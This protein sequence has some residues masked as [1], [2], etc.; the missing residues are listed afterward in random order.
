[1]TLRLTKAEL[2]RLLGHTDAEMPPGGSER[3]QERRGARADTSTSGHPRRRGANP[4]SEIQA[5]IADALRLH[6][7]YVERRN[8][9]AVRTQAGGLVRLAPVGTPDLFALAPPRHAGAH[10]TPV[11]VEVKRPGQAP[12]PA[13][14]ERHAELRGYGAVVIV[15]H[16]VDEALELLEVYL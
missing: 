14:A 9:G 16:S 4:E 5:A 12:T 10:A 2:A 6:G 1:M 8:S 3:P 7:C 15:A 13:Q 11:Y